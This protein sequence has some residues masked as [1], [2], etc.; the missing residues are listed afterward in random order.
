M[1]P[2]TAFQLVCGALQLIQFGVDSVK[3]CYEIYQSENAFTSENSQLD[4]ATQKLRTSS[5]QVS[6]P[7]RDSQQVQLQP[8]PEQR[9][10]RRATELCNQ[11]AS[12]LLKRLDSLK[13]TGGVPLPKY[14]IPMQL[15]KLKLNKRKIEKDQAQLQ[16]CKELF[17]TQM[18]VNA[19]LL[20]SHIHLSL[21]DI[22]PAESYRA[23]EW[24]KRRFLSKSTRFRVCPFSSR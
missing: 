11:K 7:L 9:E 5:S 23:V 13:P 21:A 2:A 6:D 15:A 3:A 16:Q 18:L 8:T 4:M 14:K 12:D 19:R 20:P 24:S 1:D 10:L 17:N 22:A